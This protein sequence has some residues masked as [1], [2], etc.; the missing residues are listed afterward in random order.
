M[1]P[2]D[3]SSFDFPHP[4]LT[5]SGDNNT[6]PTFASILVAHVELNV[7]AASIYSARGD[8]L[9]GHLALT[10]NANDYI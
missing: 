4:V 2:I 6:E 10:I 9:Q 7:N 1:E 5:K 3:A 8:G